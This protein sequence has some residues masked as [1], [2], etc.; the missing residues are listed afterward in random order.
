MPKGQTCFQGAAE[1]SAQG[2]AS[3][4]KG[5]GNAFSTLDSHLGR[6]QVEGQGQTRSLLIPP[7]IHCPQW[8]LDIF[9]GKRMVL[10]LTADSSAA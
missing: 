3:S 2:H 1:A 9:I 6:V 4:T 8:S 5:M 10:G 7:L